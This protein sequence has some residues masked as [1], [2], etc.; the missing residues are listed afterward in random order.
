[1][2]ERIAFGQT[3]H[4]SS[5]IVFGAAALA[6]MKPHR[7]DRVLE[8]LLEHGV[9]HIDTAAAYGDSELRVGEWMRQHRGAFFLATKTGAR[10]AAEARES[11]LRSLDRL[12]VDQVDLIQLHNL[13]DVGEWN[14][15]LGKGGA[16][17]A[18]VAARDEGLVRFL[19]VTGHGANVAARHRQSLERFEFDSVLLPCNPAMLSQ[20]DYGN[21]FGALLATCRERGVAVQ[22]IKSVARRRWRDDDEGPRHSWYAPLRDPDAVH[23]AVHFVLAH[24]GVFLNTTSD[25]SVLA[26]ILEAAEAPVRVPDAERLASDARRFGIEPL[27]EPGQDAI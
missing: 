15:A 27:F 17:E 18:L 22:T 12:Q 14:V 23:R 19:G 25:A 24:E 3:G 7:C 5:R 8:L 10:T 4:S 9:N 1:M 21:H 26:M 16:L 20:A 11:L 6:G 2:I 13:V